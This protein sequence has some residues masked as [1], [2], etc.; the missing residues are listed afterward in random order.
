MANNKNDV[1]QTTDQT[2][3]LSG[4]VAVNKVYMEAKDGEIMGL[5]GPN[6]Q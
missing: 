2:M 1:I 6:D 4:L 3:C 5:I